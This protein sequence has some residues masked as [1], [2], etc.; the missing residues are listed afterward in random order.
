MKQLLLDQTKLKCFLECERKYYWRF[1]KHLVNISTPN[2]FAVGKAVHSAIQLINT[3]ET[4]RALI[5]LLQDTELEVSDKELV[6]T[7]CEKYIENNPIK[8]LNIKLIRQEKVLTRN[9]SKNCI[10]AGRLDGIGYF[11]DRIHIIEYKTT[12]TLSET[13]K[14]SF[15]NDIQLTAY[16]WLLS[17]LYKDIGILIVFIP[18][19]ASG[20]ITVQPYLRTTK[21]ISDFRGL[22]HNVFLR[23]SNKQGKKDY[24]QS[25]S[26]CGGNFPT[27]FPCTYLPLCNCNGITKNIVRLLYKKFIWSPFESI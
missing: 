17:K 20:N 23:L 4:D 11:N 19:I 14:N 5:E 7:I 13:Y 26:A 18:K 3:D 8:R 24:L 22:V 1:H 6:A 27:F 12:K 10:F 2:Y 21:Q 16:Q 25:L 15:L 9:I